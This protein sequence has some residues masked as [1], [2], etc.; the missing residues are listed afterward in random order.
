MQAR[1]FGAPLTC[2]Q[3]DIAVETALVEMVA[4]VV[5]ADDRRRPALALLA[6]QAHTAVALDAVGLVGTFIACEGGEEEGS[7]P[8][9]SGN[10][11]LLGVTQVHVSAPRRTRSSTSNPAPSPCGVFPPAACGLPEPLGPGV[12]PPPPT[13]GVERSR[14]EVEFRVTAVLGTLLQLDEGQNP[15]KVQSAVI[16]AGRSEDVV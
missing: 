4:G 13:C 9:G 5:A 2:C 1:C 12:A 11:D 16:L 7:G 14:G 3:G 6:A 10:T 15:V 8:G